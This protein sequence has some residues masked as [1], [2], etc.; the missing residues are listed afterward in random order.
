[1]FVRLASSRI[2]IVELYLIEKN[3]DLYCLSSDCI[4]SEPL[5]SYWPFPKKLLPVDLSSSI[6]LETDLI[7]YIQE[8]SFYMCFFQYLN[9]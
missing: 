7:Q 2:I 8:T 1:M 9:A 6:Y 3:I 5:L 4:P